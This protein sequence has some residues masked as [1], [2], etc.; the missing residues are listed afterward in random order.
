MRPADWYVLDLPGDPVPGD[1]GSVGV[2]AHR[3]QRVAEDAERAEREVLG[4]AGDGAVITWLGLAAEVFR[5][6]LRDFPQ[7]LRKS[8]TPTVRP[9]RH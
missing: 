3:V 9:R 5:D 8:P 1:P 7:Q 6:A 2:L 4:L